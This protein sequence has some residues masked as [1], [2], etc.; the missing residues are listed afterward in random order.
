LNDSF[1]AALPHAI[2]AALVLLP[3]C[4]GIG[5]CGFAECPVD[6]QVSAAVRA[7]LNQY[8]AL[9]PPNLIHVHTI[10]HVVYLNGEVGTGF[11]RDAAQAVISDVPGVTRI[12]NSIAVTFEGR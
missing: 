5:H 10:E 12:V 1:P 7:R 8:P 2:I 6:A 3:G 9:G 4:V 11:Q